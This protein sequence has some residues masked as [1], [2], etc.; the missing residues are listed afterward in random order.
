MVLPGRTE[1]IEK[2]GPVVS[3]IL[4]RRF[5]AAIIDWRG[6]GLSER[7]LR[8][9]SIGHVDDFSEYQR[10]LAALLAAP[11]V[12]S[13][14]GPRAMLA[15]SMG[16]CIGLRALSEGLD[17]AASIFCAPMWG[18]VLP[19][20]ERM[21]QLAIRTAARIGLRRRFARD[22]SETTYV[23][24]TDLEENTLTADRS[25]FA[26]FQAEARAMPE[27]T[28]GGPSY[29]WLAA[30]HRE[31]DAIRKRPAPS[32]PILT[33]LGSKEA[34]VLPDPIRRESARQPNAQLVDLDGA[35]H[36]VL[37]E[38]PHIRAAVWAQIDAFLNTQMGR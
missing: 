21:S 4:T 12:A 31:F 35:R 25:A 30:A 29:G 16:G 6:Q 8:G 24:T 14:P 15:H 7:P 3:E 22:T 28:L 13:L 37:L 18:V 2:Y 33:F 17:V 1:Y 11:E 32:G 9:V 26:R 36:E 23:L 27:L 19:A 20:P 38:T 34:V 10:D 5:A